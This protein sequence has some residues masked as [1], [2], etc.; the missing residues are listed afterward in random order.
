MTR[1]QIAFYALAILVI[2]ILAYFYTSVAHAPEVL[3]DTT[4]GANID[5]S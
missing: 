1:R 3:D 4:K 2:T 5:Q